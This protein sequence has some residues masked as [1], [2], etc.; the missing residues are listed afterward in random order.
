MKSKPASRGKGPK[1]SVLPLIEEELS[2]GRETV[3]TGRVEVRVEQRETRSSVELEAVSDVVDVARVPIGREV[4][5]AEPPY[6]EGDDWVVPVYEEV[7]KVERRLVLKE[8]IR[9]RRRRQTERWQEEVV[10]RRDEPVIHRD[11]IATDAT[12]GHQS[13]KVDLPK[14]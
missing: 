12:G 6:Q 7:V 9:L 1:D 3:S 8:E 13:D 2:V 14:T 5:R 11:T 4:E 10:L